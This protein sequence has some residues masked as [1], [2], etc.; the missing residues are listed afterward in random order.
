VVGDQRVGEAG[1]SRIYACYWTIRPVLL[2]CGPRQQFSVDLDPEER[3]LVLQAVPQPGR[4]MFKLLRARIRAANT[5]DWGNKSRTRLKHK[6]RPK[7]GYIKIANADG[8]LVAHLHPTT[9]DDLF[10]LAEKFTGR[11]VAWFQPDLA[12]IN[13]QFVADLPQ[14]RT[15]KRR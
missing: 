5:W 4:D 13:V 10:Y 1:I 14:R 2:S 15:K 3:M 12:A 9:P 8:I 11:L 7:G 6:A